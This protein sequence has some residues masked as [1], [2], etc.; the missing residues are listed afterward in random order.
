MTTNRMTP[1]KQN[2]H[3]HRYRDGENN[4]AQIGA[5]SCLIDA[6]LLFACLLSHFRLQP[7]F[8]PPSSLLYSSQNQIARARM[9]RLSRAPVIMFAVT[10]TTTATTLALTGVGQ[11]SCWAADC[12][13]GSFPLDVSQRIPRA[14]KVLQIGRP[15][16]SLSQIRKRPQSGKNQ[17]HPRRRDIEFLAFSS[18]L[19]SLQGEASLSANKS[20]FFDA[21][22]LK[23]G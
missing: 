17:S 2:Q 15:V 21:K 20:P 11:L 3:T 7:F 19:Q 12:S 8:S 5:T 10:T 4:Y 1:D 6:R 22:A 13:S 16:A 18:A 14:T 23:V 9:L